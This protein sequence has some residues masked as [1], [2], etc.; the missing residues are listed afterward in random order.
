VAV[1][2]PAGRAGEIVAPPRALAKTKPGIDERTGAGVY[3]AAVAP[4]ATPRRDEP[5]RRGNMSGRA[6][7]FAKVVRPGARA[8]ASPVTHRGGAHRTGVPGDRVDWIDAELQGRK[9]AITRR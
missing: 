4:R 2:H 9:R 1:D 5:M 3:G 8:I 6:T 7:R